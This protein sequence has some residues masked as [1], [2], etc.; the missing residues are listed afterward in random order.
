MKWIARKIST[1]FIL[2]VWGL[3]GLARLF[4]SQNRAF[5]DTTQG[6]SLLPGIVGEYCRLAFFRQVLGSCGK[7][8]CIGFGTIFSHATV[9]IGER[10]YVGPYCILGDVTLGDDV[11]LAS[12]VSIANGTRQHGIRRLDIPIREQPG[13]YPR[14]HIGKDTWIGERAIVLADVGEHCV[15]GA[16]ALVLEPIPDY[17]I[18]VGVPARV[19]QDRRENAGKFGLEKS[20]I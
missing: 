11:L 5:A 18:A 17:A 15:I 9:E 16:G 8:A 13:E 7:D 10:V 12:G 2:P 6:L 20:P 4:L 14:I 19:V 3:Y 1:V